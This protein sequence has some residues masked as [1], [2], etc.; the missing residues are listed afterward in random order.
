[1]PDIIRE[2]QGQYRFLSNF[3]SCS[4]E[5]NGLRFTSTE[6]AYQAAKSEDPEVWA[7]FSHMS[8][9][10]SKRAGRLIRMRSDWDS[11]KLGV[12]EQLTALKYSPGSPLAQLLLDTGDATLIEGNTWG[13]RFWGVCGG[14]GSN[15]LGKILMNQRNIL[16]A[17]G[18]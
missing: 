18:S 2:F 6:A 7:K 15:H 17:G 1:M 11:I 3:W 5:V 14:H 4:I 9:G 16:K 8:A 13:D 12:M 10:Q